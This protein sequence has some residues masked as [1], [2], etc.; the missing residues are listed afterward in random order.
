MNKTFYCQK[1]CGSE[2][3]SIDEWNKVFKN[4][5]LSEEQ[6]DYIL[7]EEPCKKQCFDCVAI[8]G[9]R[10][11]ETKNLN[12]ISI[13]ERDEFAISFATWLNKLSPSQKVSVWSKD[14][15]Y[16]GLFSMDNEQLLEKYKKALAKE[17]V[18]TPEP[19]NN[20]NN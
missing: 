6:K 4:K 14:G 12:K 11:I 2:D 19:S 17:K 7:S 18:S 20:K 3:F 10:R 15:Q 16:Q 13:E 1:S 9:Q 8:V 5:A